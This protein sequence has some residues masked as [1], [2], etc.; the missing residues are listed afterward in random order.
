ML[1]LILASG[2]PRRSEMLSACGISY[3]KL[4]SDVEEIVLPNEKANEMVARLA[5]QKG[6]AVATI[7]PSEWVL[8]ADTTV[9]IDDQILNKPVDVDDSFR[10]L[11]LLQG[12]THTVW[13]GIGLTNLEKKIAV[14]K[15]LSTLV[16][17]KPLSPSQI[18]A[19]IETK[20][21][22]DKAGSYAI[23]GVG[24]SLIEKVQGSYSN[25]VGLDLS[26][27]VDLLLHY[28]VISV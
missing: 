12:R 11:S 15:S 10:M 4:V 2:S 5:A 19:Y 21:P 8:S 24:A 25:V 6:L 20:E 16:T 3:T 23:Q 18:H 14:T 13:G 27:T 9:V 28:G 1:P 17:M 26:A 7:K 22:M